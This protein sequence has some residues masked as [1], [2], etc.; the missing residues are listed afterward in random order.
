MKSLNQMNWNKKFIYPPS[1]RSLINDKRHYE[2]D[3]TKLPSV[4]TILEATQTS[5]KRASL[6]K[7]RLKVGAETAE[8]IK[9]T[10]ATRGT[11]MHRVIEGH[12]LGHRH[13]D[14]SDLGQQAGRMA[15][16][17]IETGL[18]GHLNEIWGS[19]I[20]V[21][22]PNLYA[23]ATDLA[24]IYDNK[25]SIVDFKQ[26]NKM[27]KR[28]WITDYF[29]QLAGYAMAHNVMQGTKIQTGVILMC[30]AQN[31]FQK[32]TVEGKEFQ[33]YMWE[34]LRRVDEYYRA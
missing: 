29:I 21:F 14:L 31:I 33:K 6:E 34:W 9:N 30:T 28:E 10:A 16:N 27:K 32:F 24:G 8:N 18:E 1:T 25:E 15:Q 26:S 22:Y 4:T 19:E 13:A 5:E 12:L 2:V 11:I 23:G 7:W 3:N 17:I 20:T